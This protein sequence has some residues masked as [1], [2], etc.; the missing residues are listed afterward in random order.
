MRKSP[1]S[2]EAKPI[3]G[4]ASTAATETGGKLTAKPPASP[5]R[6]AQYTLDY[7]LAELKTISEHLG[8]FP[9]L[10]EYR[11]LGHGGSSGVVR[12]CGMRN[13]AKRLGMECHKGR[14]GPTIRAAHRYDCFNKK[15]CIRTP[16]T[17]VD[18]PQKYCTPCKHA[19]GWYD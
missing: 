16:P 11:Q 6:T 1:M 15:L 13:L 3:P 14:R 18:H 4:T 2:A 9:S 7:V 19:R 5:R 12:W 8:R 17:K 10:E